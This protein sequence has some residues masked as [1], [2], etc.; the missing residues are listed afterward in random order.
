VITEEE[1]A[2]IKAGLEQGM[3]EEGLKKGLTWLRNQTERRGAI[4]RREKEEA[5]GEQL[6]MPWEKGE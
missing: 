3:D 4:L 1:R 5:R 6:R 2:K